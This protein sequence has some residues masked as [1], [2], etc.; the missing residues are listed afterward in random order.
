MKVTVGVLVKGKVQGVYYRQSTREQAIKIG[1]TGFVQNLKDGDVY[2]VAQ[3]SEE[4]LQHLFTWCKRG[5]L[6]ARVDSVSQERLS[7]QPD[8]TGFEIRK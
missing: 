6:L 2:L 3:G 1:V 8:F 5:P 4:Q 7:D